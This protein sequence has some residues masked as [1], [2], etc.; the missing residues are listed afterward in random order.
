[1]PDLRVTFGES[2]AADLLVTLAAVADPTWRD[3]F[4]TGAADLRVALDAGGQPY[5]RRV[6]AF[7]RFGFLNLLGVLPETRAP[8][9][10]AALVEWVRRTPARDVHLVTLGGRRRQVL[11]LVADPGAALRGDAATRRALRA[12]LASEETVVAATRWLLGTP[13]DV[14]HQALLDVLAVW[15]AA[16]YPAGTER[17]LAGTVR[18]EATG[19]RAVSRAQ[20]GV[21][22]IRSVA[23]GLTYDPPAAT[24]VLLLPAPSARPVVVVVDDVHGDVIAYPPLAPDDP[25]E[26]LLGIARALGDDTRLRILELL[27]PGARTGTDLADAVGAKRTTLLHHLAMLRAAGLLTTSVGPNNTTYY[28]LRPEAVAELHAAAVT[29]LQ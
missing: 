3:T 15:R 20:T 18:A 14:V 19:R 27:R 1:V 9:T 10:A 7:G 21:E 17:A 4:A 22:T 29:V 16:R 23:G 26:R 6:A 2:T 25:R 11:D 24:S 13:S 12:A 28:A 8:H 5:V